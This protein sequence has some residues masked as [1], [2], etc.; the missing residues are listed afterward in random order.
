M[1]T[2]YLTFENIPHPPEDVI[3]AIYECAEN[4]P[5]TFVIDY[6]PQLK[7][8]DPTQVI[9][10][11]TKQVFDFPH[12]VDVRVI[13]GDLDIH[14]DL[15]RSVAYNYHIETGG[16]KASTDFYDAD[17]NLLESYIVPPRTWAKLNVTI[18]HAVN[19][20]EEGQRRIGLSVYDIRP[21]PTKAELFKFVRQVYRRRNANSIKDVKA[22]R[23]QHGVKRSK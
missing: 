7:I 5:N 15:D 6:A 16:A 3:K 9:L 21:E 12:K 14:T 23:E 17:D 1:S 8:Y 19:N 2:P 10:E 22:W 20:I 13:R 18:P 11:W 4:Q